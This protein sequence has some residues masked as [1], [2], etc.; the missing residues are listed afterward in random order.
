[1][2]FFWVLKACQPESC[3][4]L[5]YEALAEVVD[6]PCTGWRRPRLRGREGA[7]VGNLIRREKDDRLIA[8]TMIG[9][10]QHDGAKHDALKMVA[11]VW[12]YD[13]CRSFDPRSEAGGTQRDRG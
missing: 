3:L 12:V 4:L 5:S 13:L 11:F 9:P 1:M 6:L 8:S 2:H 10:R 7:L